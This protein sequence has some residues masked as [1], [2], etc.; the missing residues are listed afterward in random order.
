MSG[1]DLPTTRRLVLRYLAGVSRSPG[2]PLN[3]AD[4]EAQIGQWW[5]EEQGRSTPPTNGE[6]R[7]CLR[8]G[9]LPKVHEVIWDLVAQRVVTP[10]TVGPTDDPDGRSA[11]RNWSY[12]RLTDYGAQVVKAQQWSP[13]DPDGYLKE[14][15]RQ[16]PKLTQA[17]HIY[18][19]EALGCFVSGRYLATAVMLGAASEGAMLDLFQSLTDAMK[20]NGRMPEVEAFER[21]LNK[22]R[23][24]FE[25][26]GEFRKHFDSLR[27]KLP[28]NLNDDLDLQLDGVF[29]LIRYYRNSSG[30]PTG[31]QVE[32][33]AAFTSLVLFLPYCK[34]TE[35]VGSW[36][37]GHA[38][39]L[40]K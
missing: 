8:P 13:H 17:Y 25:K 30:H 3:V 36:L 15:S 34:R 9:G 6:W 40:D 21:K 19:E 5:S 22:A 28:P 35:D 20:A 31:S 16:A 24:V 26:Y 7:L 1:I 38:K 2:A 29:N 10:S 27:A 33:M 14:F 39:E 18:V 4:L 32:R 12:L 11:I 37:R 23:S